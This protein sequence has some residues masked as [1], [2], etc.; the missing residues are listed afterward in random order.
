MGL[1]KKTPFEKITT[2]DIIFDQA[3]NKSF[4]ERL[5]SLQYNASLAIN[6]FFPSVIIEWNNLDKFRKFEYF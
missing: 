6:S 2:G 5:E 3:Y 1:L 4:H